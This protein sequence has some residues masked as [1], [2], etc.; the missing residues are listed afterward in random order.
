MGKKKEHLSFENTIR[1]HGHNGPFLALGYRAGRYAMERLKPKGMK[2]ICCSVTVIGRT[3]YTCIIDGIQC[4]SFCTSGKCN[5]S[6][7]DGS[8][9]IRIVFENG[10]KRITLVPRS[11]V[12][13]DALA[14]GGF[15]DMVQWRE[16]DSIE[17]LFTIDEERI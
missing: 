16:K 9:K 6:V 15:N 5:L 2:D 4:S 12:V 3:P 1:F 10:E 13:G 17:S 11:S 14:T 8:D 7:A